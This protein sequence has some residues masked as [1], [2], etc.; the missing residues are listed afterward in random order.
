MDPIIHAGGYTFT[1]LP[2]DFASSRLPS[3]GGLYLFLAF[4]IRCEDGYRVLYIGETGDYKQRLTKQHHKY[5]FC[6]LKAGRPGLFLA[7]CPMHFASEAQ[8][9]R[10]EFEILQ[11]VQPECNDQG[12]KRVA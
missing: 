10:A 11:T 1:L 9:K 12:M 2:F 8:R 3:R 7:I 5:A 6:Q 4:D